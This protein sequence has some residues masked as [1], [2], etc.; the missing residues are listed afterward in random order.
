LEGLV[1]ALDVLDA[2]IKLIRAS[3]T[4][5]DAKRDCRRNSGFSELQSQAILD[6]Q[7][8]R[9][10]ALERQKL[11]D[12]YKDVISTDRRIGRDSETTTASCGI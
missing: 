8:R 2:V 11:L 12:E 7:L 1:K 6:M 3:Q 9:L 10:A 4:T 5:D